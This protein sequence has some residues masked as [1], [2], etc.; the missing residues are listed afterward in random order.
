MSEIVAQELEDALALLRDR[1]D[2]DLVRELDQEDFAAK[3][4]EHLRQRTTPKLLFSPDNLGNIAAL[5][6]EHDP[7]ETAWETEIADNAVEGRAY[8]ASN[9]YCRRFVELDRDTFDY[10]KYE[11][12]DPQSIHGLNRQRWLAAL[13]RTYWHDRDPKY[14]EA[15]M[16]HWDFH[17]RVV[18]MDESL[19]QR[20]HAVGASARMPTPYHELDNFIRLT[21]WW[22][23]FWLALFAKEMTPERAAVLLARCLRLFDLVAAR[24]IRHHAHNF[25]AMQL[26]ALYLWA[27]ALPEVTGMTVWQSN[28]RNSAEAGLHAAVFE[29]GVQWEKSISYHVGCIRWYAVPFLLGRVNGDDWAEE[30]G[31]KL[32]R[33]GEYVDAL[34][35]PDGRMP[36]L[37]D[38]DRNQAWRHPLALL[39]FVFS[40]QPFQ[41]CVR[42]TVF[43][44]WAADG[45]VWEAAGT[46]D[47]A[48]VHNFPNAG[49]V[50]VRSPG[51][52]SAS[53]L[54]V[55]NGPT[56]AGHSHKDNMTVHYEALGRP[57]L[58]DPGR[59][60]YRQDADRSW[61]T[62]AESHN[63]IYPEPND[64][65]AGD[66]V[67]TQAFIPLS[68]G[69]PRIGA[70]TASR[71]DDICFVQTSFSGF[72]DDLEAGVRRAVAFPLDGGAPWLA[73]LDVVDGAGEQQ[74]TNSWLFPG[75]EPISELDGG[76]QIALES[77][78]R[79]NFACAATEEL[80]RRDDAMFWVPAYNSKS[81]ARWLRFSSR[82]RAAVRAFVFCPF[83]DSRAMPQAS[84]EG[85]AA[86]FVIDDAAVELEVGK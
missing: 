34:V 38:S 19:F 46:A 66:F 72:A 16:D 18:P 33:M 85:S 48:A 68:P 32:R 26:E 53:M 7:D 51:G 42:P 39:K 27:M 86:R 74:W 28:A 40:G 69:D 13:A 30:S 20:L 22:W 80:R 17:A 76:Y 35:T 79:V 58:V 54:I 41:N 6:R 37:S 44:L 56:N 29:D 21:N 31:A 24:G 52:S 15:L 59:A 5:C 67:E 43:S 50:A 60:V 23:A 2:R 81:P 11:H 4:L 55:D 78:L 73:A 57:V 62:R 71:R 64:L 83:T 49:V 36:L 10:S 77:G 82:C 12:A 47:E 14:F 84:V 8:A 65:R 3:L 61:V 75:S 70:T 45:A 25:T 63:T 1:L 9:A